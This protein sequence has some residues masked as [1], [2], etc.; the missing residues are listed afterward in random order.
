MEHADGWNTYGGP[1]SSTLEEAGFWEMVGRQVAGIELAC[2]AAGRDPASLSRSLLLGF[3]TVRPTAS[4]T[5]YREAIAR[6]EDLGFDELQVYGPF[7][8][9][10]SRFHSEASVHAEV[11]GRR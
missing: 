1:G 6:A 4:A 9:P 11:L 7:G 2:A 10:G 5:A 3:G 8:D